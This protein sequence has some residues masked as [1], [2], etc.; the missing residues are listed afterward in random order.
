MLHTSIFII[1]SNKNQVNQ[2]YTKID[3]VTYSKASNANIYVHINDKSYKYNV[4]HKKPE[5][6]YCILFDFVYLKF[7]T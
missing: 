1:I 6:K 3:T 7:K 5:A 2:K 4:L